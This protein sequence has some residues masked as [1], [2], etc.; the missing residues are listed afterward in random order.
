[1]LALVASASGARAGGGRTLGTPLTTESFDG[2]QTSVS[3]YDGFHGDF[4]RFL[5]RI[6]PWNMMILL[7]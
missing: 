7:V 6:Y 1:M 5:M 3:F 2:D 4:P